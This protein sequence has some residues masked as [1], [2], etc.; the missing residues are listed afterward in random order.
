MRKTGINVKKLTYL[1]IFTALIFVL[2]LISFFM[3]GPVFSLTF[4]L[5]PI[6]I[7]VAI[8]G[9]AAGPWLGFV[10]GIAVLVTGDAALF[11]SFDPLGTIVTVLLKGTLAGLAAALVY[12][13]IEPCSARGAVIV[14]SVVAPI[15]NTGI[16]FLGCLLFFFDDIA[17]YWSLASQAVVPFIITGL[18]G[19]NF[20][21]EVVV[22][23]VLVP[24]ISRVIRIVK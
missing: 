17:A 22:N 7:A 6:V 21:V 23:L 15:V 18:I 11:L 14:A 8:C 19:I 13:A 3:R 16:F 4:V 12:K 9:I 1:A 20:I 5:V 24:V 10:F 2:Q